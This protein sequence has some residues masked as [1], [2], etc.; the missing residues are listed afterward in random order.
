MVISGA[1]LAGDHQQHGG[2]ADVRLTRAGK[3][4]PAHQVLPGQI[5]PDGR[6]DIRRDTTCSRYS[7]AASGAP[8]SR[9]RNRSAYADA[10]RPTGVHRAGGHT[11][12][13]N[14]PSAPRGALSTAW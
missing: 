3:R 9:T 10:G 14:R 11:R 6:S 8:T 7:R 1:S 4:A 5:P 2:V 12:P 13:W